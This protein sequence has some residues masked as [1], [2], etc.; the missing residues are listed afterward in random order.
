MVRSGDEPWP[1]CGGRFS[2][3]P[4]WGTKLLGEKHPL[5]QET[6]AFWVAALLHSHA[7]PPLTAFSEP[8]EDRDN[9]DTVQRT[10]NKDDGG[11]VL[12]RSGG[13]GEVRLPTPC[14][15]NPKLP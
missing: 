15:P 1:A 4:S 2:T 5:S 13:G 14:H 11:Q 9:H 3:G 10:E 12:K 7:S 8:R 6:A